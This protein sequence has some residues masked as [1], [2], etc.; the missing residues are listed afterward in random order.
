MYDLE[1]ALELAQ[2]QLQVC[3]QGGSVEPQLLTPGKK[4]IRPSGFAQSS[5]DA[6]LRNYSFAFAL[7]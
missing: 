7:L 3:E 4:R 6:D 5:Y 1:K 2:A